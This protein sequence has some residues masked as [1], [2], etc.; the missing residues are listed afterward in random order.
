MENDNK[1]KKVISIKRLL[2]IILA[3]ILIWFCFTSYEYYRVKTDKKP[4]ICFNK[5]EINENDNEKSTMCYGLFYK[6]KEY[7]YKKSGSIT[8]REFA[9]FFMAMDRNNDW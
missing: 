4:L 8:G 9:L 2:L 1:L 5:K 3:L 6:Y 7:Y